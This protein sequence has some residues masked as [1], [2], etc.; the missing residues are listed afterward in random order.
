MA[1]FNGAALHAMAF[2][3]LATTERRM[4]WKEASDITKVF[5]DQA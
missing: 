3:L 5:I 2:V 4:N 1:F